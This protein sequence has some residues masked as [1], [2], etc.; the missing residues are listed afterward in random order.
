MKV[1]I[2]GYG[3]LGKGVEKV[4][5][6]QP[7]MEL[8]GIFT[9]RNPD[10]IKTQGSPIFSMEDM[11]KFDIDVCILC[12]GSAT[13]LVKQS[14]E[15]AQKFNIVDSYDTHANIPQHF[16]VLDKVC[17]ENNTLSMISTGWDPGVFSLQ[18]LLA[19]AILPKGESTT[20]W[21]KGV[22]QGHSDAI[23]R[24]KGVV[25][26]VQY[27]IP[28]DE[29]IKKVRNGE[30]GNLTTREKHLRECYVIVENPEDENRV[31]KEICEMPNYFAD[32]DT[33]VHFISYEEL[34]KNHSGMPHGG[35]V[36]RSGRT[37]IET[38]HTWE[39]SLKLDSNPEF[40]ASVNVA[41]ARAV[42]KAYK[43]GKRGCITMFDIPLSYMS[44]KNVDD[45]Y[46]ELL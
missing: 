21:G 19:E 23:R 4:L 34:K 36:V 27:T 18:R 40:T 42:Y 7:D 2:V 11:G 8:V 44:Y 22:S 25:D 5:K 38:G 14:P 3:N 12:G 35:I 31:K 15:I 17:K 26:A 16:K 39:F 29:A 30:G 24:I 13:D 43:E 46:R 33:V 10:G 1:A 41:C 6:L 45:L 9:R 28:K 37:D 32:Y 20:F